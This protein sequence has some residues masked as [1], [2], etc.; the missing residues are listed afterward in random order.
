MAWVCL[1]SGLMHVALGFGGALRPSVLGLVTPFS[2]ET[3]GCLIGI[4]YLVSAGE[5]VA[6]AARS[7]A[8]GSAADA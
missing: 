5:E 4:I 2:C 7:A 6:G 3:F 8:L 1:F